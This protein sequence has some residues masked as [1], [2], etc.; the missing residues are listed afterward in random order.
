MGPDGEALP[1]PDWEALPGP[2]GEALPSPDG[3]APAAGAET[4][5]RLTAAKALIDKT[6]QDCGARNRV[7]IARRDLPLLVFLAPCGACPP[8]GRSV[9]PPIIPLA[10]P[11]ST[12]KRG[13][14]RG[15]SYVH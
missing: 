14:D 2:G 12:S 4:R 10:R 11:L 7:F 3:E 9:R 5:D 1:G 6:A 8:P 15:G 13:P